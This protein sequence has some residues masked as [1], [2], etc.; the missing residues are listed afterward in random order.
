MHPSIYAS[1]HRFDHP[2]GDTYL[3][4]STGIHLRDSYRLT[5][6][7]LFRRMRVVCAVFEI[8]GQLCFLQFVSPIFSRVELF[9]VP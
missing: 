4:V 2:S 5:V 8:V 7:A 3:L 6:F 9:F 1:V